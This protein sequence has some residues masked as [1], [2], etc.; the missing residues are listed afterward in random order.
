MFPQ[1]TNCQMTIS[2]RTRLILILCLGQAVCLAIGLWIRTRLHVSVQ[3]QATVESGQVEQVEVAEPPSDAGSNA[4]AIELIA[5]VWIA[6]VQSAFTWMVIQREFDLEEKQKDSHDSSLLAARELIRTR[7]A[8]IFGLAKL[9]DSRDP[10]TGQHLERISLYSMRLASALRRHPQFS[11]DINGSFVRMIGISSVLHDIGK[12]GVED[13]VLLKAGALDDDER[14]RIKL[15]AQLGADCI[16]QIER[17]LGDSDFLVMAREIA[18]SHHEKWDGSGYP[19]GLRGVQIP[20]AARIVAIADVYDA[21]SQKRVYKD[22]YAHEV[23][24]SKIA[25]D[26]GTHFDPQMIEVF[27]T[28]EHQFKEIADKFREHAPGNR[29][30][31]AQERLLESVLSPDTGEV[32]DQAEVLESPT[33]V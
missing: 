25:T 16:K 15:H 18:Q 1:A 21:L 20:L 9:A 27:L 19:Q 5:Y 29:M 31:R 14:T 28:I 12:V 22:A 6:G 10:E 17:Q 8:I 7:D 13:S 11:K 23:C 30:S 24:V 26:A 32:S 2:K 33:T 3:R 4:L